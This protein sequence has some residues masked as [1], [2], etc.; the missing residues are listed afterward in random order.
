[1]ENQLTELEK[2]LYNKHLIVSRTVKNK[3]FKLK[4][5]F[6]KIV[7]SSKHKNLKRLAVF[8]KKHP[9]INLTTF[10]EA[11]YKLYPDVQYFD[12]E[13]FSSLRAIK[14]YTAYKKILFLRD[15]DSQIEEVKES[16]R[17]IAEFCCKQQIPFYMYHKHQTSDLYTWM[18]HYKENKINLYTMM[19]FT[20]IYSLTLNLSEDI[21]G[22]FVQDFIDQFKTLYISYNNSRLLKSYLKKSFSVLNNFVSLQLTNSKDS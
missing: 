2:H 12:L 6:T 9:E 21:R 7:D 19:E 3:P 18:V 13:Y 15:P 14:A 16:L 10:F 22:F 8:I 5:D 20:D 17:F 11:P 4:K 1:M